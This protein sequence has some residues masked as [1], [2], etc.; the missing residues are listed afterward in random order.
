M[1]FAIFSALFLAAGISNAL[2]P[3][4]SCAIADAHGRCYQYDFQGRPVK[5]AECRA[6]SPCKKKGDPCSL[7][8]RCSG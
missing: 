8:G 1:K 6:S 2:G 3:P 7:D 5:Y 4:I